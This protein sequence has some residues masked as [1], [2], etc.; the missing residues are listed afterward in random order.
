MKRIKRLGLTVFAVTAL[1]AL[2]GAGSA[3]AATAGFTADSYPATV[4]GSQVGK[5]TFKSPNTTFACEGASLGAT[6]KGPSSTLTT[7]VSD[8][9]GGQM[10]MNGCSYAF[11]PGSGSSFGGTFD[12]APCGQITFCCFYTVEGKLIPFSIY[13]KTGMKETTYENV[14]S[15]SSAAVIVHVK[16]TGVKYSKNNESALEDGTLEGTWQISAKN[17]KGSATGLHVEAER[18]IGMYMATDEVSGE[19]VFGFEQLPIQ[20]SGVQ[21]SEEGSEFSLP[22]WGSLNCSNYGSPETLYSMD[23]FV[24][25]SMSKCKAFGVATTA[26]MH[27]CG[28]YVHVKS[29]GSP[30][31]GNVGLACPEGVAGVT[32]TTPLGPVTIPP[33]EFGSATYETKGSGS[34]REVY[35]VVKG[36]NIKYSIFGSTSENGTFKWHTTFKGRL[37]P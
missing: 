33:Q 11:H 30:Y 7:E 5:V 35:V 28:Y 17:S 27:G 8:S 32:Y 21:Q 37:F 26:D 15:G 9:C 3:V 2:V 12:I 29:T 16:V 25:T 34:G 4:S 6:L 23:A 20:I 19:P 18:Q 14:G 13:S 36:T 24:V 22:G 10:K 1:I 31:T